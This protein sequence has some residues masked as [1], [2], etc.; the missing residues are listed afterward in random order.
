L[1]LESRHCWPAPTVPPEV[2][3]EVAVDAVVEDDVDVEV[4]QE[5]VTPEQV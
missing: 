1:K 4:V 5:V 2:H 3:D